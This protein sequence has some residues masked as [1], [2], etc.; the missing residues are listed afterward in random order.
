[1]SHAY[2]KARFE[3]TGE[4]FHFE[5]NGTVNVCIPTLRL[6]KQEVTDHWRKSNWQKCQCGRPPEPVEIVADYGRGFYWPGTACR[7]C[8]CLVGNLMPFVDPDN[9]YPDDGYPDWYKAIPT[10][11]VPNLLPLR[12][13]AL[14]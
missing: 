8:L 13:A 10:T 14:P 9:V 7:T 2:G 6:T 1:M 3:R 11:A 12:Q 4:I 5:Y